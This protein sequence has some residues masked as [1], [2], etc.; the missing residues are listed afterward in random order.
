MSRLLYGI[1]IWGHYAPTLSNSAQV[2]Q[3]MAARWILGADRKTK[4]T[5]LLQAIKWLSIHQLTLYHSL[6]SLWK[7]VRLREPSRLVEKLHPAQSS[8]RAADL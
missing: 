2:V 8:R 7:I 3:N 4:V 6:L 5:E 1:Q